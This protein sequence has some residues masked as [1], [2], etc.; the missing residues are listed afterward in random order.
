MSGLAKQMNRLT[1][2]T[3]E[4]IVHDDLHHSV[5]QTIADEFDLWEEKGDDEASFPTWLSRIVEGEM[6]DFEAERGSSK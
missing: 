3:R 1:E 2:R 5:C 6:R 4:I